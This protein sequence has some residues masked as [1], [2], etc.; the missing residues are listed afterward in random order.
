MNLLI[1]RNKIHYEYNLLLL[2]SVVIISFFIYMFIQNNKYITIV[3]QNISTLVSEEKLIT[4]SLENYQ[5]QKKQIIKKKAIVKPVKEMPI[6]KIQKKKIFKEVRKQVVEK[7]K[8]I[9]KVEKKVI[10]Q[11]KIQ[12]PIF[13]AK[14]K[15]IF[16]SGLYSIINN[17]KKYPKMAKRRRLEGVTT[18]SFTLNKD[19][20]IDDVFL[21]DSCGH[22]ILDK[23][24]VKLINS[25]KTYESIPD[26]VSLTALNLTIPIKYSR[27]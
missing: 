20:S 14:E 16:I 11:K 2:L 27:N 12:T 1:K 15:E 10:K 19:G 18:V 6:E 7:V 17:N 5:V 22:R 26:T 25:I 4:I 9:A 21:C 3:P 23:A 13:S 8:V 24:S